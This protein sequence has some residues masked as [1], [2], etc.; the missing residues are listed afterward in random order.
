MAMKTQR[1]QLPLHKKKFVSFVRFDVISHS[2]EGEL[3]VGEAHGAQGMFPKLC[4]G[5][6][7]PGKLVV[8]MS[9]SLAHGLKSL[10]A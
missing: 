3:L 7:T 5:P 2:G 6:S 1:L 10:D 9:R 4:L 8:E